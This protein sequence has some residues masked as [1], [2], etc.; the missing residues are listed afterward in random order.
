MYLSLKRVSGVHN[1]KDYIITLYLRYI[2]SSRYP[3]TPSA[4][5]K[6]C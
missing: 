4:L 6:D 5:S 1:V 2:F 3:S